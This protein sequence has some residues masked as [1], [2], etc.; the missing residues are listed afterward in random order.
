MLDCARNFFRVEFIE[1]MLE[2]AAF[3]KLN[4]FHWH[5]TDDQAWRIGLEK[6]PELAEKGAFRVD[7]RFNRERK[8]GGYY[9]PVDIRRVVAKAASLHIE[10][11]PEVETPGHAVA[12]LASHPELTCPVP[13]GQT[14]K[15]A[16]GY[17]VFE[18]VLCAGNDAVFDLLG[19]VFDELAGIFPFEVVHAGGDEV[20][21]AHWLAC[22]RCR[23]RMD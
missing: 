1:R 11:V 12:I 3:H 13:R 7:G 4:R 19:D 14:P 8:V 21:K 20:P 15:P 5:L 9:S 22:P 23:A 10:V 18:D 17:G 16:D 2:L 6:H